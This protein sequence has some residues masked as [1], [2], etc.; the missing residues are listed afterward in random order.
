MVNGKWAESE[1]TLCDSV[2]SLAVPDAVYYTVCSAVISVAII[3]PQSISRQP[4]TFL[5]SVNI[6]SLFRVNRRPSDCSAAP[7]GRF[8]THNLNRR[9]AAGIGVQLYCVR[10][11]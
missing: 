10:K 8:R 9:E 4:V 11:I 3:K 5:H 2:Y 6:G 7:Y 1:T